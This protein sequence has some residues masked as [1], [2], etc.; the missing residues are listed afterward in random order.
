MFAEAPCGLIYA[1]PVPEECSMLEYGDVSTYSERNS[2]CP[3]GR[4]ISCLVDLLTAFD[5]QE[6]K[7]EY[8][9]GLKKNR[10]RGF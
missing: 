7:F 8:V 2:V 1:V 9:F 5:F 4:V 6:I 10:S 3:P